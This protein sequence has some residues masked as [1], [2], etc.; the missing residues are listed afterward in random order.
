MKFTVLQMYVRLFISGLLL[1]F[2]A[3]DLSSQP[4]FK[5][6]HYA[7]E[8]GLSHNTVL[9]MTMDERGFLWI[10]TMDGLNRFDGLEMKTYRP[11][12]DDSTAIT[13]GFIHGIHQHKSGKL[14]ISTRDGGLTIFDPITETFESRNSETNKEF[15]FPGSQISL[16]YKDS[17]DIYWIS[18]FGHSMGLLSEQA[19]R[20]YQA[21]IGDGSDGNIRTSVNSFIEFGDGSMLIS[22]LNGLHYLPSDE[23]AGFRKD[24]TNDKIIAAQSFPFSKEDP[25]P[26]SSNLRI[27]SN[28]DLWVNLVKEGLHKMERQMLPG[29][30]KNSIETG[31]VGNSAKDLVIEKDGYLIS[32]Y[33]NN[34]LLFVN[35]KTGEETFR[36]FD[37][38]INLEGATYL[39]EDK[40]GELWVYLWGGGFY[41]LEQQ[42]GISLFNNTTRKDAFASNFMLGFEEEEKGF[43]I[44]TSEEVLFYDEEMD[45]I[46]S[47]KDDLANTKIRGIWSME[48]DD[49]GLWIATNEKGLVF[50]SDRE[51]SKTSSKKADRFTFE[52]SLIKSKNLRQVFRDSHGWLWLGYEGDGIQ[53]ITDPKAFLDGKPFQVIELNAEISEEEP[54]VSS[55][56]IRKFYEDTYGNMWVATL[57]SGFDRIRIQ[58]KKIIDV[59][60]FSASKSGKNSIPHNDGRD[61]YQQDENTFWF[62]TYGGGIT[63]WD[64][65][66]NTFTEYNTRN[67]LP[68]NS[69]Y[70]ILGEGEAPYLW[71]STNSGLARLNT[72]TER[73]EVFTEADGLQNNEFNTGAYLKL[74][75]GRL[76]FGGINGFNIIDPSILSDYKKAPPV[77]ITD[78][79]LFNESLKMDSSAI[80]KKHLRLSY[81]ENFLSFSFAALDFENPAENQFSYKMS[82]VDED[83]VQ[84]GNRNFAGYPNLQ[85]GKYV[86]MV[87]ASNSDGIWN[88]DGARIAITIFPPWWQT[89][90]FRGLSGIVLLTGVIV[91]VRYFSQRRLR[92]QIRKMEV[93][94]KLRNERERI[95]RDLHDH[96][97]SQLANIMSGLS[98]VDKYNQVDNKEK[99]SSL[100]NSLRGDAEVTIKQLRETIW[101]L[102]QNSLD[103]ITFKENLQNYFK[104]QTAFKESLVFSYEIEGDCETHLSS[105]QALNLFRIIQEASQ[106]TLKYADANSINISMLRKNGSLSIKIKDDGVFKG[107]QSEFNGGYGFGNMRKR[108]QELGGD[109]SV[110]T[111]KGTEVLVKIPI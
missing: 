33:L 17:K 21:K 22:S 98:L 35:L 104:N 39:Y 38:A 102:N 99:S 46:H 111:E 19:D 14:W 25:F 60:N 108:A 54:S 64:S 87:K 57:D 20:Y 88:N 9:G 10:A 66:S 67:G 62:A 31:V 70:G 76:V 48:R 81:K 69:T 50:L 47:L 49:L 30:L 28:G 82:G 12:P 15:N 72:E 85:P 84:A 79:E 58:E 13:D 101:A 43:W 95:S 78:V 59:Q 26:N 106:N 36:T 4:V 27:D 37:E 42:R 53:I 91:S 34:R 3:T 83:W 68:N 41:K 100:M 23:V 11:D 86:F 80:A 94:N 89:W 7:K 44:G 103:L 56:N 40:D 105:T 93:E 6:T 73:F 2:V 61:V 52:N 51:I 63:K 77:Y 1:M 107:D 65:D 71:I 45:N 75:D 74:N 55:E 109:I 32:G 92:E 18:F 90:W 24:P 96:V 97:G 8:Q 16:L 29:F 5:K 110:N